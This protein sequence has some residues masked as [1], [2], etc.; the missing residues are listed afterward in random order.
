MRYLLLILLFAYC[1]EKEC[2]EPVEEVN[3]C[4]RLL[5]SDYDLDKWPNDEY[6]CIFLVD[7]EL[8][9]GDSYTF[10]GCM[11]LFELAVYY[12]TQSC[13]PGAI[14]LGYFDV[15]MNDKV[16]A[17]GTIIKCDCK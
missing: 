6:R 7:G 1:E 2:I 4:T 13:I 12:D 10:W 5:T 16:L 17:D 9:V 8:G 14:D 11:S 15:G 3:P